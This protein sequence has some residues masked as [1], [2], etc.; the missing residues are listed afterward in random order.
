MYK[1]DSGWASTPR[2]LL[3]FEV[4]LSDH[5]NLNCVSCDHFSPLAEKKFLDVSVFER[6]CKRLSELT[7]GHIDLID[8]LG[9]E[10]LLHPELITI[11]SIARKYFTGRIN[12]VTNGILLLKQEELFWE[13]CNKNNISI[14]ISCYPIK[15]DLEKIQEK[16]KHHNINVILRGNME[17]H[18]WYKFPLDL[19]GKQNIKKNF[20]SCRSANMCIY[21]EDGKL[22]TC[23]KPLLIKH[24]NSYFSLDIKTTTEDYIDIYKENNI[25]NILRSLCKPIPFCRYCNLKHSLVS[26]SV[27]QKNIS[28]WI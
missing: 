16:A 21:L 18:E 12:I 15:L 27:S 10:P 11:M 9:G 4:H 2:K 19:D 3:R 13:C 6:D 26:W 1:T 24:F 5:C 28:E 23:G 14:I 20:Y 17:S 8:L 22:S 25:K 7:K